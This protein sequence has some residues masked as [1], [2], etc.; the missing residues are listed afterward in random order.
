M[1][2][3]GGNWTIADLN[4]FLASPKAMVPGTKMSFDGL[5]RGS[6]RAD[7]I[8]YL[9]SLADNPQPLPKAAD[10]APA[11]GGGQPPAANAPSAAPAGQQP[12]NEGAHPNS[13]GQNPPPKQ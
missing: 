4:V 7:V 10:A 2:G 6:Q 5:P 11:T 3:K 13:Q 12:A 9:N 8:A 1:K